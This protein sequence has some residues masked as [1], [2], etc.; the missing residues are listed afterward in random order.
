MTL[1]TGS[2]G[3]SSNLPAL[4]GKGRERERGWVYG[5]PRPGSPY[6]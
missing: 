5:I 4:T 1:R 6:Y 2:L 3:T